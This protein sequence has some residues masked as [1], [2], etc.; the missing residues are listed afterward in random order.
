MSA[1]DNDVN[2]I[3][4]EYTLAEQEIPFLIVDNG[5]E[6][7]EAWKELD[8]VLILM[9]ISM[10]I[11][12]GI[13]AV[14]HIREVE[15]ITGRHVP[16]VALTAH[17]CRG[18][19]DRILESGADHYLSKPFNPGQLLAKISEILSSNEASLQAC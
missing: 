11:M 2:Q 10:P 3:V 9:D 13:E 18:D 17:V 8:P 6:A 12:N 19:A 7:I 5:A 4:L 14:H 15:K 16:I 1:E